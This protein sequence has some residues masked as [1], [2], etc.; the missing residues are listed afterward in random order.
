MIDF[1]DESIQPPIRAQMME[2][3]GTITGL[4]SDKTSKADINLKGSVERRSPFAITGKLSP[5]ADELYAEVKLSFKD[6]D[7][8]RLDPYARKYM[9]YSLEKGNLTLDSTY[10]VAKRSLDSQNNIQFDQLTLGEKVESPDAVNL[11]IKF[12]ISLLQDRSGGIRLEIPVQGPVDDPKFG[13]GKIIWKAVSNLILKAVTAPFALL[14][15]LF[16]GGAGAGDDLGF[17]A[18]ETGGGAL[19]VAAL[20]KVETVAKIMYERPRLQIDFEGRADPA[21]ERDLLLKARLAEI[22]KAQKAKEPPKKEKESPPQVEGDI[23]PGEQEALLRKAIAEQIGNADLSKK[24]SLDVIKKQL[25]GK[26][27]VGDDDVKAI[28]SQRAASVRDHLVN[29]GKIEA[30]RIFLVEPKLDTGFGN[31]QGKPGVVMKLK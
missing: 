17:V 21:R 29:V 22:V 25:L 12:A 30:K 3:N 19:S 1:S 28:A 4:S 8:T 10:L 23:P 16:G 2:M 31:N 18:F 14:G 9:G 13:L 6:V 24:L 11:P 5:F 27:T 26:A 15:G 20:K 7:M